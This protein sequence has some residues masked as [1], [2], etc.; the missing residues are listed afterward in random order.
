M[1]EKVNWKKVF[2]IVNSWNFYCATELCFITPFP[3]FYWFFSLPHRTRANVFFCI[4]SIDFLCGKGKFSKLNH[5]CGKIS[6]LIRCF[7]QNISIDTWTMNFFV[8]LESVNWMMEKSCFCVIEAIRV[9]VSWRL[10]T[11]Y[12]MRA[13]LG[14]IIGHVNGLSFTFFSLLSFLLWHVTLD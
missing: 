7:I 3:K 12:Q 4:Y 8:S 14:N 10:I 1:L 11:L 2:C 6:C 5:E 13:P 9:Y